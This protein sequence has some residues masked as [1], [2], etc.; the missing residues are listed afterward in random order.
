MSGP[1]ELSAKLQESLSLGNAGQD[2]VP[3]G[4]VDITEELF[5][6]CS[7]EFWAFLGENTAGIFRNKV[8]WVTVGLLFFAH[9]C[10]NDDIIG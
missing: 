7:G 9:L 3:V 5:R 4:T 2:T 1:D 8:F 10:D 6:R